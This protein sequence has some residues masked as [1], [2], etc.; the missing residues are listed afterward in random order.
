[1]PRQELSQYICAYIDLQYSDMEAYERNVSICGFVSQ[2]QGQSQRQRRSKKSFLD[3]V[4]F[5]CLHRTVWLH[6]NSCVGVLVCWVN[7]IDAMHD[8]TSSRPLAH[9]SREAFAIFTEYAAQQAHT[10]MCREL[11]ELKQEMALFGSTV[12]CVLNN[13]SMCHEM[14]N[15]C[16]CRAWTCRCSAC[17]AMR[18]T[19]KN[20]LAPHEKPFFRMI[21]DPH[22]AFGHPKQQTARGAASGG[23]SI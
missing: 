23:V 21:D 9:T 17:Q 13:C 1:V 12:G 14:P 15:E 20:K 5:V 19:Y 18:T 11:H 10:D 2:G 16:R 3:M 4:V 6:E 7:S 8:M 22:P